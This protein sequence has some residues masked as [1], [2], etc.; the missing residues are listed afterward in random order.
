MG[1]TAQSKTHT[2]DSKTNR[3]NPMPGIATSPMVEEKGNDILQC[4]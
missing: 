2:E 4:G 3:E 1:A